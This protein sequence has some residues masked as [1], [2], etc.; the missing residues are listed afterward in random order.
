[1]S[2]CDS[3]RSKPQQSIAF[4]RLGFLFA[5]VMAASSQPTG[6]TAGHIISWGSQVVSPFEP[7]MRF[8]A[9]ASGEFFTLAVKIDGTVL[10]W[11]W[12]EGGGANVPADLCDVIAVAASYH[13]LALRSDG[14]VAAWGNNSDGQCTVPS[15]LA[16]VIAVATGNSHSLALKSDGTVVAWGG[17]W[18]GAIS[19]PEGLSNVVSIAAGGWHSIAL[20]DDGTVVAWGSYG[21]WNLDALTNIVAISSGFSTTLSLRSD[22]TVFIGDAPVGGLSNVVRISC[23]GNLAF[24]SDGNV[25][26]VA[27]PTNNLSCLKGSIAVAR[28]GFIRFAMNPDGTLREFDCLGQESVMSRLDDVSSIASGGYHGIALRKDGTVVTFG[29]ADQNPGTTGIV[30]IAGGGRHTLALTREGTVAAWGENHDG[31]CDV[32]YGLKNVTDIAGGGYHS[33]ALR[34]D[35]TVIAWGYNRYGQGNGNFGHL[36]AISAGWLHS[37]GLNSNGALAT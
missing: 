2:T 25:V 21:G 15:G 16:N 22:G 20:K 5:C 30:S 37:L 11:G 29:Q 12:N 32:P 1:V 14:T 7:Q 36:R 8:R 27:D 4:N 24:K 28:A 26:A 19:V 9:I 13:S 23:V 3:F 35:G 31:Q 33:L 34:T 17:N 18:G 10:A 6:A